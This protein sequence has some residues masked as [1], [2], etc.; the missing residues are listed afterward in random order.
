MIANVLTAVVALLHVY[1]M[2]LEMIAWDKP[3][4]LKTFRLTQEFASASKALAM[5]Q[6]LYNGFLVAGLVWGLWLGDAGFAIKAFFLGCVIVAG[7]FGA[8][9]VGR[10][11]L[12]VQAGPAL[13]A[14][15]ALVYA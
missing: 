5:N 4:G 2:F 13:L 9:T 8:L 3:L 1:F 12:F 7:V 6:G 11:I 14:L 10:K 15:L